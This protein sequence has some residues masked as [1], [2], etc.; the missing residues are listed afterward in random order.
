M[1]GTNLR[2]N[3]I[4]LGLAAFAA[5]GTCASDDVPLAEA[6]GDTNK[7]WQPN[8]TWR[9]LIFEVLAENG[10]SAHCDDCDWGE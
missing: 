3:E 2:L 8:E 7:V 4:S 10:R 5:T 1:R 6:K 9:K